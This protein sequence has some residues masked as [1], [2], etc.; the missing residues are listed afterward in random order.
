MTE[1]RRRSLAPFWVLLAVTALP[2]IG[3]WIVYFNPS[4]LGDFSTTNRGGLVTPVRPLPRIVLETLDGSGFD[5][6]DLEGNWK[7]GRAHV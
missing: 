3:A 6:R 1:A 5:T 7:I 2:F 4:L